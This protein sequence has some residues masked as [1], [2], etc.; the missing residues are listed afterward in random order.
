V[1]AS[2]SCLQ[3]CISQKAARRTDKKRQSCCTASHQ[4]SGSAPRNYRRR[5]GEE[6][7]LHA[8]VGT[9]I[10]RKVRQCAVAS[11]RL[12]FRRSRKR[13]ANVKVGPP[14]PSSNPA[15]GQLHGAQAACHR[16]HHTRR[17]GMGIPQT[18]KGVRGQTRCLHVGRVRAQG[19]RDSND[20]TSTAF[21]EAEGAGGRRSAFPTQNS[22]MTVLPWP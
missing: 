21:V 10:S 18:P 1:S 17:F 16:Q 4:T 8:G 22:R 2:A 6:S 15:W 19:G 3:G 14:G 7:Q 13:N 5:W 9:R 12:R 20:A 11:A